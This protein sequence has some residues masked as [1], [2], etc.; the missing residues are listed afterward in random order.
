VAFC[1]GAYLAAEGSLSLLEEILGVGKQWIVFS[2]L[3]AAVVSLLL[4]QR[5]IREIR[6]V[7][8]G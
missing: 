6:K 8:D 1:F 7:R 5:R 2:F 4:M 3:T